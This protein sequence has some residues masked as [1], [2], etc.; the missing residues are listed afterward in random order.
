[1][2]TFVFEKALL[3]S[4][5]LGYSSSTFPYIIHVLFQRT[6][7]RSRPTVPEGRAVDEVVVSR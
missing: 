5:R 4:D 3:F 6:S 7:L 2:V 1:M